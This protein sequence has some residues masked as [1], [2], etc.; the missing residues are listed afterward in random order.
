MKLKPH[1]QKAVDGCPNKWGLWFKMRVGK[2]PTAI[3]LAD[4]RCDNCLVIVPKYLKE[5]WQTEIN[6][7]SDG[8]CSF[9]IIT[10]ETFRRDYKSLPAYKAIIWDEVHLAGSNYKSQLFK[11]VEKYIKIHR[12]E[13]VWLLTGT[14][15]TGKSWSIY[16]Y[17]KLLGK[18]WNWLKWKRY[19]F[20][21]IRMGRRIVPIPRTDKD[22][23]LQKIIHSIGTVIDLKDVVDIAEDYDVVEYFDLNKGQKQE[24]DNLT[25]I[26]PITRYTRINQLESGVLKS[27]GYSLEL[28]I[29]CEKDDRIIQLCSENDKI[30]IV[31][32]Y[33]AL[34]DKYKELLRHQD[35]EIFIISGQ[36]KELAVTVAKKAELADKAIVLIQS[37]TVV[38]YDLKSF[39]TM[40]FASL[41]YSFV[42]YDQCRSRIKSMEKS[43]GNTYIHLLIRGNSIDRA[44]Y[45][46][47]KRKEDFSSEL[48]DKRNYQ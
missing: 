31:V 11:A 45:D 4:T 30:V 28:N 38:G 34:I 39:S 9:N 29:S 37:D 23:D 41:S 13:F 18:D 24:I 20:Y 21:E 22:E 19:F 47:V 48:F 10:K 16:S 14:P 2:T 33:L 12:V 26:L 7:W 15:F 32:R 40:V 35:K 46:C 43:T 6:R 1:Q 36:E 5:Q 27:D 42:N 25:D 44:I 3:K 17:G 8:K